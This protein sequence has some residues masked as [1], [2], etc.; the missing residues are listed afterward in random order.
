MSAIRV[1][2]YGALVV[3]GSLSALILFPFGQKW[4][5]RAV[6]LLV[7]GLHGVIALSARIGPFS[8]AMMTFPLLLLGAE[9]FAFVTRPFRSER[10]ARTIVLDPKSPLA[11]QAARV[12]ARLDPFS[13]LT[14][15]D[16]RQTE[17]VPDSAPPDPLFVVDREGRIFR[18]AVALAQICRAL[19]FGIVPRAV[20]ALPGVAA[21]VLSR[22]RAFDKRHRA[23]GRAVGVT[24]R[25]ED[26]ASTRP[27]EPR[28]ITELRATVAGA[29]A[30][31]REASV[32]LLGAAV[33]AAIF[34]QNGFISQH[35]KLAR[36]DWMVAVI[37]YPR[38]LQGWSMFA[39]EP[40]YEDGR[41]V[42][43]GRTADGRKFD[44]FSGGAP[45]FNPDSASGWDHS[46]FWCDYH[47]R[48]RFGDNAS[49][50]QHLR[51]Y[52]LKQ[53]EFNGRPETQLVAFDVWWV[54]GRSPAPGATR[55]EPLPPEKLLSYG[56]VEDSSVEPWLGPLQAARP[57]HG[58]EVPLHGP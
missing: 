1:M 15:V 4:T 54:H 20:L 29:L 10:R 11:F 39:P 8:Y 52:L 21:F 44:P 51:Q 45:D 3:E 22:A 19:P 9:D 32:V 41:V 5:R 27:V 25:P 47:N 28:P 23:W 13:R 50:R 57:P 46:Q 31:L 48:I 24:R 40:P 58:R 12:L 34:V 38:L 49:H 35:V 55:G 16:R 14:F 37:E 18:H 17:L 33:V 53:H 30:S 26:P 43:D 56:K 2:T 7:W 36:S 6:L 42:I